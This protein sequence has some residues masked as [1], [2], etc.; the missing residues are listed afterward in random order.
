MSLTD[1][2]YFELNAIFVNYFVEIFY[3]YLNKIDQ[4]NCHISLKLGQKFQTVQFGFRT[5]TP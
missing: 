5:N 4:I 2:I 3:S 1:F